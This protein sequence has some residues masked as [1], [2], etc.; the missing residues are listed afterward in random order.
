MTAEE[1]NTRTKQVLDQLRR[2]LAGTIPD[3]RIAELGWANFH[4]LRKDAT[5]VDF[6]PLLVQ[7]QTRHELLAI[8]EQ[9]RTAA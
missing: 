9:L 1:L 4:R 7:R 2:E 6:I 5:I 3:A 8:A